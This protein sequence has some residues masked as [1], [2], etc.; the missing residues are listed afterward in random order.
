MSSIGF[1]IIGKKGLTSL[2][3]VRHSNTELLNNIKYVVVGTDPNVQND[4]SEEVLRFCTQNNIKTYSRS[5]FSTA[6]PK[7]EYL[8]AIGWKWLIDTE[9]INLIVLHDSL[10]PKYRG[11]NPL[12][13]ALLEGDTEIGVTAIEAIDKVD[14]GPI[15][16]QKAVEITYPIKIEQAIDEVSILYSEVVE[17]L[18]SMDL[19]TVDRTIQD[20]S[21][22]SFS[23][24]RNHEDYVIDWSNS[25]EY[26]IRMIH[27]VGYPYQGA[28]THYK[29]EEIRVFDAEEVQDP[30]IVNR[31]AGKL[32]SIHKNEAIVVC[33]KGMVK[34]KEV[35]NVR[36]ESFEFKSLRERLESFKK[37][38][39]TVKELE[40][41]K[42]TVENGKI[43]ENGK[44][45]HENH[46]FLNA[47]MSLRSVS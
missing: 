31:V 12:V 45:Y 40:L 47:N 6:K 14:A 23:L 37:P 17:E 30:N 36:G 10:L 2:E 21:K 35:K 43:S 34:I 11:F 46:K 18:L 25:A 28:L 44:Y 16:S 33:G 1:L 22:A 32:F 39:N 3:F 9:N 20:E 4:Y 13:T 15:I 27:A 38:I 24:W 19:K 7:A 29:G 8:I 42:E 5:E 41:I 26:I